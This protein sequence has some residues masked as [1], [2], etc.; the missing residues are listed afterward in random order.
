MFIL[1]IVNLKSKLHF[2]DIGSLPKTKEL[3]INGQA[4]NGTNSIS[5]IQLAD[6]IMCV[7]NGQKRLPYRYLFIFNDINRANLKAC[8][9]LSES[10]LS[11][12]IKETLGSNQ[13]KVNLLAHIQSNFQNYKELL[14]VVQLTNKI[15]KNN[16]KSKHKSNNCSNNDKVRFVFFCKY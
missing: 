4:Y 3:T 13:C 8:L 5:L 7:L 12:L 10:K 6:V 11:N 16:R 15:L 2:I 9:F 1:K 14:Q